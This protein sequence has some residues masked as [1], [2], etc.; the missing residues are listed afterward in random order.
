GGGRGKVDLFQR[1]IKENNYWI[2]D[3][4]RAINPRLLVFETQNT[5]PADR[6]LT[7]EYRPDFYCWDKPISEQDCRGVS[8]L[9]MQRLCK[10][11][12]YR[13]IGD[14]RH[15]FNV[16]FLRDEEGTQFFTEVSIE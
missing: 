15:G 6:S 16:F 8:L 4:I 11:R 3:Q 9:A 2:W 10:R 5:I 14:H 7:I 12:G 13:M 1:K